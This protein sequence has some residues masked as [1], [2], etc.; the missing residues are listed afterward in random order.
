[1]P[2]LPRTL[3]SLRAFASSSASPSS[4]LLAARPLAPTASS[5]LA[6]PSTFSA[7]I[8]TLFRPTAV[9]S[10]SPLL[11]SSRPSLSCPS[12]S[13]FSLL[14]NHSAGP[15]QLRTAVYGAEYQPSQVK[16]KRKHGFLAR[17]RT[18]NGR[19][20]L[21]NRWSKGRKYLSH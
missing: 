10:L 15:S 12:S 17:V 2:R 11:S 1:M 14:P 5:S 8:S 20:T 21:R 6:R 18:K 7:S 3:P 9:T 19:K 16:R 4:A 13:L